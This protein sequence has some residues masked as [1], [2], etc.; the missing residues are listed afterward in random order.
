[1]KFIELFLILGFL[2][3]RYLGDDHSTL[4]TTAKT[5]YNISLTNHLDQN[6][7]QGSSTASATNTDKNNRLSTSKDTKLDIAMVMPFD[8]LTGASHKRNSPKENELPSHG[9]QPCSLVSNSREISEDGLSQ[10]HAISQQNSINYGQ[11]FI[12]S[13]GE[14]SQT[15]N[16]NVNMH[17]MSNSTRMSKFPHIP[18]SNESKRSASF[19]TAA[20]LSSHTTD[21]SL[22]ADSISGSSSARDTTKTII[23]TFK[24]AGNCDESTPVDSIKLDSCPSC[25]GRCGQ[26]GRVLPFELPCSCDQTCQVYQDCCPDFELLCSEQ[27]DLG[28]KLRYSLSGSWGSTCVTLEMDKGDDGNFL[29]ISDCNGTKYELMKTRGVPD[30]NNGVPVEDMNTGLFFINYDCAI[31]HGARN[32]RPMAIA[33]HYYL[34]P[35]DVIKENLTHLHPAATTSPF[36]PEHPSD[37]T[38][39]H[40]G[41]HQTMAAKEDSAEYISREFL[42]LKLKSLGYEP[43]LIYTFVGLPARQCYGGLIDTCSKSC[44]NNNLVNLCLKSG[45][46][47][48]TVD[49]DE[50]VQDTFK[51]VY[52]AICYTKSDR[53]ICGD[54]NSGS[55]SPPYTEISDFSLSVLFDFNSG[56]G[57]GSMGITCDGTKVI[58]PNG[59]VCGDTVCPHEFILQH[60]S[61]TPVNSP[62]TFLWE[63][64]YQITINTSLGCKLCKNNTMVNFND[65]LSHITNQVFII[66]QNVSENVLVTSVEISCSCINLLLSNISI[67]TL[68]PRNGNSLITNTTQKLEIEGTTMVLNS[69]LNYL[70]EA[71]CTIYFSRIP[72]LAFNTSLVSSEWDHPCV[73]GFH[74]RQRFFSTRNGIDVEKQRPFLSRG[75]LHNS[76][77]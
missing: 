20:E 25:Q 54:V 40:F 22:G 64:L 72:F 69:L 52:C 59:M 21:V 4:T 8:P 28:L 27:Y 5:M 6:D 35:Y 10:D 71:N 74:H 3:P 65:T 2:L 7:S 67:K 44:S 61:C 75:R 33:L 39:A 34:P 38:A 14:I 66:V 12:E 13:N 46:M 56:L 58:L 15:T 76:K 36:Y 31:C 51:N 49:E 37:K 55:M 57:I 60:G 48:T 18:Y 50:Y 29:F 73:G 77:W 62:E 19:S 45:F 43:T 23:T 16:A 1:M 53:F 24:T 42:T 47:Y 41:P 32:L 17:Q 9:K 11:P 68:P 70:Y 63:F 30:A 26:V